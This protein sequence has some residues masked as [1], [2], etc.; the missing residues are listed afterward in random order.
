M[1][2]QQ[3]DTH[4][5][6]HL[7]RFYRYYH[8]DPKMHLHLLSLAGFTDMDMANA[9]SVTVREMPGPWLSESLN[10]G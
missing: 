5:V 8:Q 9:G 2:Y 3:V 4:I 10:H 6:L 1:K 7:R